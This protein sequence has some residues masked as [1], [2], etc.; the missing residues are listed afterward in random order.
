M[1]II[2]GLV[3]AVVLLIFIILVKPFGT[4]DDRGVDPG[5]EAARKFMEDYVD[6]LNTDS[7][8]EIE[9]R[10]GRP[11]NAQDVQQSL[12]LFG[13]RNLQV[14]DITILHEFPYVYRAYITAEAD[15]GTI[16]EIYQTFSWTGKRWSTGTLYTGSPP[17]RD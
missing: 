15:D 5:K 17:P 2:A 1:L 12:K 14:T 13:G 9:K 8:E 7:A 6:A 11:A 10:L 16:V 3:L 4:G